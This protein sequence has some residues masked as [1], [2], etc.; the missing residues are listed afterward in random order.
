[1]NVP[2]FHVAFP[3][4]RTFGIPIRFL[5]NSLRSA[6]QD[7]I[8]LGHEKRG[9]A[10][11]RASVRRGARAWSPAAACRSRGSAGPGPCARARG[12]GAAPPHERPA[13]RDDVPRGVYHFW[14]YIER[15]IK[16]YT[17]IY[18]APFNGVP[19]NGTKS[20]D[21]PFYLAHQ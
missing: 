6:H 9:S 21:T 12:A 14:R 4:W 7:C 5:W 19:S 16:W 10:P 11:G 20:Y 1:M 15:T 2:R 17:I 18:S 13:P 8:E 3:L